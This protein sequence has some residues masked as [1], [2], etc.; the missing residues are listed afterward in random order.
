MKSVNI[1]NEWMVVIQFSIRF[2]SSVYLQ[3]MCSE[4]YKVISTN[5]GCRCANIL[6]RLRVGKPSQH[7]HIILVSLLLV[8][9]FSCYETPYH[10]EFGVSLSSDMFCYCW[11]L[12]LLN[13]K[14][15]SFSLTRCVKHITSL[16]TTD[17]FPIVRRVCHMS[18][19]I[20][21]LLQYTLISRLSHMFLTWLQ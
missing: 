14:V 7:G 5:E 18:A 13:I 4:S 3:P 6:S 17:E 12:R 21:T 2:I 20:L 1:L 9:P 10:L 16:L 19:P 8:L 15:M 11:F